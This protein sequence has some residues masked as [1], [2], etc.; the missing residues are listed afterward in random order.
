ME[1]LDQQAVE[2]ISDIIEQ[3]VDDQSYTRLKETLIK[4]FSESSERQL[5]R[6]LSEV[7][8]GDKKPS[9]LLRKM[10]DLGKN[11]VTDSLLRTKWMSLL[12]QN[13]TNILLVAH[14]VDLNKLAEMADKLMEF[15]GGYVTA[16]NTTNSQGV[17]AIKNSVDKQHDE[18]L[19]KIEKM[20]SDIQISIKEL[21]ETNK[22]KS[23]ETRPRSRSRSRPRYPDGKC[24][25]HHKFGD[26]AYK[27]HGPWC[28]KNPN[29]QP[30]NL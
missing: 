14:D 13:V 12:P 8:L 20:I 7:E 3:P 23:Q 6:L 19:D 17:C 30:G 15:A 11:E 26:A 21:R 29:H 1:I 18:R 5:H 2:E 10:R 27:C 4:R 9:Q 22:T 28:P 24:Y 25:Y 16:V